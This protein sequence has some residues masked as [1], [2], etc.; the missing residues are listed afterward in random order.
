MKIS[1]F[2]KYLANQASIK[3]HS[4]PRDKEKL[5]DVQQEREGT[6]PYQVFI[7]SHIKQVLTIL[8]YLGLSQTILDYLGLSRT[9]S[10]YLK[11]SQTIVAYL[12]LSGTTWYYLVISGTIS[13]YLVL[14]QTI[15][16]YLGLGCKQ[17]RAIYCYLKLFP[18][19][20]FLGARAPLELAHVKKNNKKVRK[21]FQI[22][23][24]CSLLLVVL[25]P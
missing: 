12:I 15:W 2:C 17:E 16:N 13:D 4:A 9:I 6:I 11:L 18:Y 1:K 10:D 7:S 22:A 14:Y 3:V 8:G 21:K 19:I 24:N 23:I 25:A 5:R 20:S